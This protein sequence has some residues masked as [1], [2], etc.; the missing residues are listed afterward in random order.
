MTVAQFFDKLTLA[1]KGD[2]DWA[3]RRKN[4]LRL[5]WVAMG[6]VVFLALFRDIDKAAVAIGALLGF[7]SSIYLIYVGGVVTDDKDK[8][9]QQGGQA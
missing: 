9:R 5:A 6:L 7:V 8:R 4:G 2:P 1:D 3:I